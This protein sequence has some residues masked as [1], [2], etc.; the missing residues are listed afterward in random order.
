MV[1]CK[2]SKSNHTL[3]TLSMLTASQIRCLKSISNTLL[4]SLVSK[5]V[6]PIL[7][8][9]Q[10]SWHSPTHC[11][12]PICN[13]HGL[14]KGRNNLSLLN[15]YGTWHNGNLINDLRLLLTLKTQLQFLLVNRAWGQSVKLGCTQAIHRMCLLWELPLL[16]AAACTGIHSLA[17]LV[18]QYSNSL[19][20]LDCCSLKLKS[21]QLWLLNAWSEKDKCRQKGMGMQKEVQPSLP[22]PPELY[23]ANNPSILP[24]QT[25]LNW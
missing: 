16:P 19:L 22:S 24:S 20:W 2:G 15:P 7:R 10:G 13:N 25:G 23:G 11:P 14:S 8:A 17:A 9:S 12:C 1:K 4:C 18:S 6:S 5:D 21:E 3:Q